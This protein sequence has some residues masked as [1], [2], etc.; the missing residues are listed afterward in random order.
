MIDKNKNFIPDE[1]KK[2]LK[3]HPEYRY[4]KSFSMDE[5]MEKFELQKLW[6]SIH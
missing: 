5:H 4:E 2:F 1:I 3:E 6:G